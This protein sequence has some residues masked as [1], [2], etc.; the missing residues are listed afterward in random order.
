MTITLRLD[1]WVLIYTPV[2]LLA[3]A[4][5]LEEEHRHKHGNSAVVYLAIALAWPVLGVG[6]VLY[7]LGRA[8]V[9]ARSKRRRAGGRGTS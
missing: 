8:V 4:A 6:I 9:A 5:L 2:M 7:V 1:L 3:L